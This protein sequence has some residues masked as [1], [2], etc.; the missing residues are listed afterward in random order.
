M[1]PAARV[2]AI[3]SVLGSVVTA[4]LDMLGVAALI[5]L[6]QL[7]T[8]APVNEGPLGFVWQLTG[9]PTNEQLALIILAAVVGA[10]VLKS[11]LTIFIRWW[12]LGFLG[13]EAMWASVTLMRGY[14]RP[15]YSFHLQRSVPDLMRVVGDCVTQSYSGVIG[16]LLAI[17]A[18]G[19]AALALVTLLVVTSPLAAGIALAY[20]CLLYTSPSPRD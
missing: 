12:Q 8:G 2:K 3:L 17:L 13:R 10:F 4:A 7:L 6:T 5:P 9:Q 1:R 15:P 16:G 18:E 11:V 20:L 19:L 14:L